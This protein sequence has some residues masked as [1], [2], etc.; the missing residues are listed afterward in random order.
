MPRIT[1]E[2][3]RRNR[4]KIVDA[5][6][7]GFRSRGIDGVG[8]EEVMKNAGMTHGGFYNH[9]TSKE[10]LAL[11]VLHEGFT[12][13][14]DA[15]AA[16]RAAHPRSA[17]AAL[18]GIVDDYL[19]TTH[20]DHPESGCASAA[21]VSDAGRHGAAAQAEYRRGLE[22][23]FAAF[24]ELLLDRARQSDA[25]LDPAAAREHAI[26]V[27]SQMVGAL[28]LSRAVADAEPA[29]SDEVLTANRRQ[30]KRK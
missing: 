7:A 11:E 21:L 24:T 1:Q 13:S 28:V 27:F 17:R 19:T 2:Q 16:T 8:I 20:R 29:L 25:E 3:K 23:Y 15:V 30:L 6:G 14:L 22:G 12:S 4:E 18:N 9:F 10:A 5:A 26:A